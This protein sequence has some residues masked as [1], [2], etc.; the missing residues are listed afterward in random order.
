MQGTLYLSNNPGQGQW[1]FLT[2]RVKWMTENDQDNTC[3][4]SGSGTSWWAKDCAMY[5]SWFNK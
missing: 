5:W 4:M 2:N 3:H 1:D